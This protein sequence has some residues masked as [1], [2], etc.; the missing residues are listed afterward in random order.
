MT[1]PTAAHR[2][3][4]AAGWRMLLGLALAWPA[5]TTAATTLRVGLYD[6]SPKV[7]R[8]AEGQPAGLFVELLAGMARRPALE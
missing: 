7:Y 2:R 3:W 4:R 8:D 5:I 6:N 1:E